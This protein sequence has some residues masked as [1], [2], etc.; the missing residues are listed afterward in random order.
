[1]AELLEPFIEWHMENKDI[2]AVSIA[3]VDDQEIVWARGFGYADPGDSTPATA[4]TVY[5]VGSVSKLFTDMAVM[6]LVERGEL[7]LDTPVTTYLPEFSPAS[8]SCAR[9]I[10]SFQCL[11]VTF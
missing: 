1:V 7:E 3:L 10:L 2:P 11:Q 4:H 8:W 5:R 6:Q 9:H